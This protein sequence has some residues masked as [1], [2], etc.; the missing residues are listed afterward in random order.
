MDFRK[1]SVIRELSD[2]M[3]VLFASMDPVSW[4]KYW[5]A[6][7]AMADQ[8]ILLNECNMDLAQ[9]KNHIHCFVGFYLVI[10]ILTTIHRDVQDPPDGWVGMLVFGDY[11]GGNRCIPDLGLALYYRPGDVVFMRSW[12]LKHF[13]T[14]YEGNQRYVIVFSTTR[15]IFN[16]FE[17]QGSQTQS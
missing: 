10:N 5:D 6:Y 17:R 15:F 1:S 9:K 16:W 8:F 11:R 4:R 14:T 7:I 2:H 12:A 13:I 3:S